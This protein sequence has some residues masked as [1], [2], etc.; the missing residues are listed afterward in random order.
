MFS[1][2]SSGRPSADSRPGSYYLFMLV[3]PEPG[4]LRV[5]V[6]FTADRMATVGELAKSDDIDRA[7]FATVRLTCK[8]RAKQLRAELRDAYTPWR[9]VR[10]TYF[11]P[12]AQ[13]SQWRA[14]WL[15]LFRA[16]ATTAEPLAWVTNDARTW[17][18]VRRGMSWQR[19]SFAAA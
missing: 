13:R 17:L 4:G 6:G 12:H 15:S 9:S 5:R 11:I 8:Q 16:L 10:G 14:A 1:L 19:R 2:S 7:T 18:R 3:I